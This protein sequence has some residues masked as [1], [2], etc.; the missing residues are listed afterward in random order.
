M[1]FLFAN[2]A[3]T[4]LAQPLPASGA[5]STTIYLA[6]GTG[7]TFPSPGEGQ[8]FELTL[9]DP[10][11]GLVTEITYCTSRIGDTCTVIRAQEGTTALPWPI[12]TTASNLNTA[13]VQAAAVQQDQ[14]QAGTYVLATITAG[15]TANAI[16]ASL[17]SMLTS[18]QPAQ[19]VVIMAAAACGSGGVTLDLTL[20]AT[21]TGAQPV[22][23]LNNVALAAGDIP[24]AGYPMLLLWWS[25][26]SS[27]L[28][29]NPA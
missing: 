8:A 4:T 24:A 22:V 14:L 17:P 20:G 12:G 15:S 9:S 29:L 19:G 5:G 28:L 27:W 11:T 26:I 3:A 6:A 13:G 10:A 16:K 18:L 21:D 7:A 2:D 1:Q 25:T 23:K